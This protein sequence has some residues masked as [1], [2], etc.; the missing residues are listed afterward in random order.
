AG[1]GHHGPHLL[2]VPGDAG[3][4]RC[5]RLGH[6]LEDVHLPTA[7]QQH[8]ADKQSGHRAADDDGATLFAARIAH[9]DD[10]RASRACSSTLT[11]GTVCSRSMSSFSL[12]LMPPRHGVKIM[13]A[14]QILAM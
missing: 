2:I 6:A 3:A 5:Q 9:D 8:V 11:A 7:A 10:A 4:A 14:G 1:G 12:W 13:A